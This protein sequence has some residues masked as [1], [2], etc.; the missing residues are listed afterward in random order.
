VGQR[1][2]IV[3]AGWFTSPTCKNQDKRC[4]LRPKL[5]YD[6]VACTEFANVAA[7]EIVQPGG[8]QVGHP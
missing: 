6:F 8:L 3:T 4:T 1:A 5:V 2:T 7:G